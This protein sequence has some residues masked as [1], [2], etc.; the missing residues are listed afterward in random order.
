MTATIAD[1]A[2]AAGDEPRGKHDPGG[3]ECLRCYLTRMLTEFGCDGTHRWTLRW[4]RARA[5]QDKGLIARVKRRGGLCCDCE[6]VFNALPEYPDVDRLL[7][8]AGSESGS[9][10]ACDLRVTE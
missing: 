6:V 9:G 8:C 1:R 5:P 7:P 10:E 2:M 4:Q 3:R